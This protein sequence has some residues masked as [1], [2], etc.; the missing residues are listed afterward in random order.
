MI[1]IQYQDYL[2]IVKNLQN[3]KNKK[4][5]DQSLNSLERIMNKVR[6]ENQT[7]NDGRD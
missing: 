4:N 2:D 7:M 5:V 3:V 1:A 6:R